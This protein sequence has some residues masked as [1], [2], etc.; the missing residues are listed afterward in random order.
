M[1]TAGLIVLA[2]PIPVIAYA[3]S[4]NINSAKLL[5]TFPGTGLSKAVTIADTQKVRSIGAI[6]LA[7]TKRLITVGATDTVSQ[8]KPSASVASYQKVQPVESVISKATNIQT[9]EEAVRAPAAATDLAAAGAALPSLEPVTQQLQRYWS[10]SR[11]GRSV[12]P[13]GQ[14]IRIPLI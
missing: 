14:C 12:C 11:F 10:I 3:S 9:H 13:L 1:R 5:D 2:A 7:N 8:P 6:A 4:I